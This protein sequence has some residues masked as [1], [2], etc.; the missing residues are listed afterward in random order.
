VIPPNTNLGI[1]EGVLTLRPRPKTRTPHRSIDFFL[2]ALAE[3]QRERA[4][5][6]PAD[7]DTS[8]KGASIYG[9]HA[10]SK[11][12]V[13][14]VAKQTANRCFGSS[15]PVMYESN[16]ANDEAAEFR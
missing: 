9:P 2:E 6:D 4:I 8:G 15:R 11:S 3:D 10:L 13:F 5:G 14:C 7:L 1:T 16:N 12:C